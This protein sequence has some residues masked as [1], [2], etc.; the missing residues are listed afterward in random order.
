MFKKDNVTFTYESPMYLQMMYQYMKDDLGPTNFKEWDDL[1][2]YFEF[3]SGLSEFE[4]EPTDEDITRY[5]DF[6]G[7]N[8]K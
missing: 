8:N 5:R 4:I 3:N 2:D 1:F 6:Q 7:R